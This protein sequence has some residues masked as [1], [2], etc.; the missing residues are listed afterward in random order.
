MLD[1]AAEVSRVEGLVLQPLD[2]ADACDLLRHGG[3]AGADEVD[4]GI[5]GAG[6][7]LMLSLER[8]L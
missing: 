8:F 7:D 6:P 4:L 3:A 2:G 1:E 5:V